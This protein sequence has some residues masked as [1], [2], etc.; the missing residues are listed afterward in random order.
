MTRIPI[1]ARIIPGS[2]EN[3][4]RSDPNYV[5]YR[6]HIGHTVTALFGTVW[7]MHQGALTPRPVPDITLTNDELRDASMASRI[8]ARQAEKDA[9]GITCTRS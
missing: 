8:A 3:E 2:R 5:T 7:T 1:S 4:M 6:P 9:G